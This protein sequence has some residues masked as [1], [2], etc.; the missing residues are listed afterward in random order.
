MEKAAFR[1]LSEETGA[2]KFNLIPVKI[3]SVS[4]GKN[5]TFGQ[6]FYSEIEQIDKL[7]ESEIIEIKLVDDLPRSL[8]YPLIQPFL[9]RKVL[10][11]V[12]S[13]NTK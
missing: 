3:Y 8:T 2:K 4:D 5:Q 13:L 11:F 9:F 12:G 7:P 1:E 10:E 6:L